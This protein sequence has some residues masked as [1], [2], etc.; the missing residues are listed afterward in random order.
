MT[1]ITTT[2]PDYAALVE[3]VLVN[4]DL[5]KLT[6]AE[7]M[8]Y[9]KQV[10]ES[11]GLNPLTKPFEYI[12]LNGKMVLYA[13]R[14]ATDQLR[15]IHKISVLETTETEREGVLII[16]TKVQNAE[17]RTDIARGAVNIAG[18]NGE[19]LAN[20]I[21]KAETKAK[22]RATLSICGLGLLD[23]TEVESIPNAV[24][25]TQHDVIH[26]PMR[27]AAQ[28]PQEAATDQD[29]VDGVGHWVAQQKAVIEAAVSLPGLY[30]WMEGNCVDQTGEGTVAK[31]AT[32][33][34]LYRLLKKAPDSFKDIVATYQAKAQQLGR[35]QI[36]RT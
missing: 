4:G 29:I 23:E 15:S 14:G 26:Q 36:N 17:G 2:S 16:T 21:L 31:P 19:V 27:E 18:L 32:G 34:V 8:G 6:P 30:A 11:T 28:T 9:Y 12:T 13:L 10:C 33:T 22:R 7:R 3:R 35:A 20:A 5:S 25:P 1:A 24:K